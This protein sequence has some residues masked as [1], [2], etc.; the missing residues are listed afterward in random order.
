MSKQ[1]R[2]SQPCVT[3]LSLQ[4][5]I[6]SIHHNISSYT[7]LFVRYLVVLGLPLIYSAWGRGVGSPGHDRIGKAK[8]EEYVHRGDSL[9][10]INTVLFPRFLVVISIHYYMY[11]QENL[12]YSKSHL[13]MPTTVTLQS[14]LY[15]TLFLERK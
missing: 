2:I 3:C 8:E 12:S 7:A 14:Q 10:F 9:E 13:K 5:E 4:S 1:I 15:P 11:T 6:P